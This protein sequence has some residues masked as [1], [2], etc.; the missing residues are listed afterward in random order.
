MRFR[1]VFFALALCAPLQSVAY[2]REQVA[3]QSQPQTLAPQ[4]S[5]P[6]MCGQAPQAAWVA[7]VAAKVRPIFPDPGAYDATYRKYPGTACGTVYRASYLI[8]LMR[9][10]SLHIKADFPL[11]SYT[12]APAPAVCGKGA[13]LADADYVIHEIWLKAKDQ[14]AFTANIG[15]IQK[16]PCVVTR[17]TVYLMQMLGSANSAWSFTR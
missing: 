17:M 13:D 5:L 8:H 12:P 10:N 7:A 6:A 3:S 16:G 1:P 15:T 4:V 9:T 2:A 14:R 11:Q